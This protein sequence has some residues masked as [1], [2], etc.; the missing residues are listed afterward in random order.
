MPIGYSQRR[1]FCRKSMGP[2][3]WLQL[4]D[5]FS[6]PSALLSRA[7][8]GWP[9]RW[10]SNVVIL[11]ILWSDMVTATTHRSN[12]HSLVGISGSATESPRT[13]LW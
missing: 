10:H 5:N 2:I 11:W 4:L 1:A 8:A 7:I 12:K 3:I 13:R 9:C 6:W